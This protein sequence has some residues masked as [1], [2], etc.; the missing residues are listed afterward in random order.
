MKI[1]I[2]EPLGISE[3]QA[4]IMTSDF[5]GRGMDLVFTDTLPS[6]EKDLISRI[7]EADA[8][9]IANHPLCAGVIKECRNLKFI[10]VA[11]TG[12][13]HVDTGY[14][15]T[16]GIAVSNCAGY[17]NEAVS[18]LVM[19]MA[20]SLLRRLPECDAAV[21]KEGTREGLIG[22]EI[23][24]KNFGIIGTGAIGRKT[25]ALAHAFGCHVYGYSRTPKDASISYLPLDELMGLCDIISVHVPLTEETKNLID[26]HELSLMK[27]TAILINAARGPI[28]DYTALAAALKN[29]SIAGAGIDVFEGEPPISAGH[30]LFSAPHV[31]ASPHIGF[32]TKEAM[33]KRATIA[34]EN[35]RKW[36]D[37]RQQNIIC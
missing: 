32:A 36:A 25:A 37:G 6:C 35:I 27:R 28:V 24:G 12:T 3:E 26:S 22:E 23:C 16:H 14:C 9:I 7:K 1:I 19:G 21:R 31:L 20:V 29:G 17:S 33:V 30:P 15:R 13:E 8:V 2:A 18:E 11:F 5:A 10:S 4:N 34:F